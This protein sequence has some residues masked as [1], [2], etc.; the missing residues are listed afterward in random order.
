MV[1]TI[2]LREI[3]FFGLQYTDSKGHST[4]LKLNKKVRNSKLLIITSQTHDFISCARL[5]MSS[6]P[7]MTSDMA[8]TQH[9]KFPNGLLRCFVGLRGMSCLKACACCVDA[10]GRSD[11]ILTSALKAYGCSVDSSVRAC[12][13]LTSMI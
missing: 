4:W 5:S 13:V 10:T 8:V 11:C 3:W 2:G 12:H 1:K 6:Y 7:F 9:W